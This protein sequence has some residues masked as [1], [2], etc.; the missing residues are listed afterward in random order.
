MSCTRHP[1]PCV[2]VCVCQKH[3]PN[4]TVVFTFLEFLQRIVSFNTSTIEMNIE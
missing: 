1:F 3:L 2:C 4:L